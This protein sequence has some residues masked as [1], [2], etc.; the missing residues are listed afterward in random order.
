MAK[1]GILTIHGM[2]RHG[3]DFDRGLRER[4]C[5]RF[6]QGTRNDVI[7]QEVFFQDV[8]QAN[9]TRVWAAMALASGWFP[10]PWRKLWGKAREFFLFGFSDAASYQ[11][12]PA[13]GGSAYKKIHI[14]V[15]DSLD[16]LA[17]ALGDH[18]AP[19]VIISHSLGCHV[20]SNY[21]WDA[22]HN[23]HIWSATNQPTDFQKLGTAA[24]FFTAGCNIP[25]FVSG[26]DQIEAIRPPNGHFR[27]INYYDKDDILG[28]PL[29]P[30]SSSYK[31]LVEDVAL[32]TRG[33]L[34]WT[35]LS[36][37]EYWKSGSFLKPV[38][39][40]INELHAQA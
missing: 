40:L 10:R 12:R 24:Y 30:L 37:I 3:P 19:V 15:R 13:E 2:G 31:Q 6:D 5:R 26:L 29:E 23:E 38:A 8:L 17:A 21:I 22:Q 9:E 35:P 4:L 7:F 27:W 34:S 32:R 28:W 11:N 14:K 33:V 16:R 39:K 18:Q 36:H 1:I 25:I 20:I